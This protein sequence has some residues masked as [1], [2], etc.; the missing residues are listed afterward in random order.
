GSNTTFDRTVCSHPPGRGCTLCGCPA[1]G[2]V[3]AFP[4]AARPCPRPVDEPAERPGRADWSSRLL[5]PAARQCGR[6]LSEK[7]SRRVS[8]SMDVGGAFLEEVLRGACRNGAPAVRDG[9]LRH[10]LHSGI[11]CGSGPA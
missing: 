3:E 8:I 11:A 1:T 4:T 2:A 9:E 7:V 6:Q 10:W 5:A